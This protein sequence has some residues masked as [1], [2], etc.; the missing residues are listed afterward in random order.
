MVICTLYV[1]LSPHPLKPHTKPTHA[2]NTRKY[3]SAHSS[4]LIPCTMML[5]KVYMLFTTNN[6]RLTSYFNLQ[7]KTTAKDTAD[8]EEDL[9]FGAN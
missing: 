1:L 7:I 6:R 3:R 9:F 2:Q 5:T 8:T 4:Y